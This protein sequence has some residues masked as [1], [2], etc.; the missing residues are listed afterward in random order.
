MDYNM[1]ANQ[2]LNTT[3]APAHNYPGWREQ[4]ANSYISGFKRAYETNRAPFFIGN[5][6][7]QWNGGIYMDAVEKAFKHIA[8]E[9]E[10][11]GDVRLVSFRQFT[12]W[13]DVQRPEVLSKLR[14]L[15]VGERP[16]GGWKALFADSGKGA[17][18][19][20]SKAA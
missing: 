6:F 9:K 2:S 3:R 15:D 7:E 12:D 19:G 11:G 14:S 4:A 20:S 18:S 8:R 13:L 16:A 1:L 17:P 10:K 5:H